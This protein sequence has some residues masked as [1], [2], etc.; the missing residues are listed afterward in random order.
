MSSEPKKVSLPGAAD[1][2]PYQERQLWHSE[3]NAGA[4]K[5]PGK[6]FRN[7]AEPCAKHAKNP[8][9]E[10]KWKDEGEDSSG[11]PLKKRDPN[12][13]DHDC[14]DCLANAHVIEEA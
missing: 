8:P 9:G 4:P 3:A 1:D 10:Q 2:L 11:L 7:V 6:S 14:P 13:F 12:G 5:R